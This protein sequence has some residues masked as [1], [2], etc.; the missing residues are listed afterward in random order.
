MNGL[1]ISGNKLSF[2]A[3]V[4]ADAVPLPR[5]NAGNETVAGN[6]KQ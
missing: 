2:R 4:S 5:G 1:T 3:P 6:A